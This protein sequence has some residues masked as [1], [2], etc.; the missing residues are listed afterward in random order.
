MQNKSSG[1]GGK[2]N[3]E[4]QAPFPKKEKVSAKLLTDQKS[5]LKFVAGGGPLKDSFVIVIGGK[6]TSRQFT[7]HH[8]IG[9]TDLDEWD[10]VITRSDE[11]QPLL[12]RAKDP[13]AARLNRLRGETLTEWAVENVLLKKVGDTLCY[14]TSG[15]VRE[16]VLEA[17]RKRVDKIFKADSTAL[18][19]AAKQSGTAAP[20]PRKRDPIDFIEGTNRTD[21]IKLRDY[22]SSSITKEA[23]EQRYPSTYRTRAGPL[24]NVDQKRIN[25]EGFFLSSNEA[26]DVA[27]ASIVRLQLPGGHEP[28]KK[29]N[30]QRVRQDHD[31]EEEE[32]ETEKTHTPP[33]GEGAPQSPSS[34]AGV[35]VKT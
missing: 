23:V 22:W 27:V 5:D 15:E 35:T 33:A 13:D 34:A 8:P 4:K 18:E 24:Q 10:W 3:Q 14:P 11:I 6:A 12:L 7:I 30:P 9:C 21:E 28:P 19:R 32:D 2:P 26:E 25:G 17:A 31:E 20:K 29:P 1:K 16:D